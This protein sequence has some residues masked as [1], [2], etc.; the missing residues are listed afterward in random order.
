LRRL[1]TDA[2]KILVALLHADRSVSVTELIELADIHSTEWYGWQGYL[3]EKGLIS[4]KKTDSVRREVTL[5]ARGKDAATRLREL[6]ILLG[7]GGE[8]AS[9][10]RTKKKL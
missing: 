6:M 9:K 10:P 8:A 2:W 5:T 3:L 4:S 7:E 1:V